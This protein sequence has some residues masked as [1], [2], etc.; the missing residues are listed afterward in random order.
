MKTTNMM[1]LAF[2]IPLIVFQAGGLLIWGGQNI[3]NLGI[4]RTEYAQAY[5]SCIEEHM[6]EFIRATSTTVLNLCPRSPY[7]RIF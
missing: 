3:L 2:M 1:V 4:S 5:D 7:I 6:D